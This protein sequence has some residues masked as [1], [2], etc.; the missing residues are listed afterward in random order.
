[1]SEELTRIYE[2]EKRL[3][4]IESKIDT[5]FSVLLGIYIHLFFELFKN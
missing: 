5:I 3:N 2:I 1:M 4:N